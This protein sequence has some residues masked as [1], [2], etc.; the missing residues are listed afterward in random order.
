MLYRLSYA[1]AGIG[2]GISFDPL[3]GADPGGIQLGREIVHYIIPMPHCKAF[4]T[5]GEKSGLG[6]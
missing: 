1:S 5:L 2:V 6:P 4:P 3:P